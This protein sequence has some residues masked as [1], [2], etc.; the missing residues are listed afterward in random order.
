MKRVIWGRLKAGTK[1]NETLCYLFQVVQPE[2]IE[3]PSDTVS[4]LITIKL[5]VKKVFG[6]AWCEAEL[7]LQ[8]LF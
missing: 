7:S 2:I 8:G 4:K 6:G 3:M 1:E 5:A